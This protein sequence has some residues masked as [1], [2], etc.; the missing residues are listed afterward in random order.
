MASI[1]IIM[2]KRPTRVV[3]PVAVSYQSVLGISPA[4]AEPL[5][6]AEDVN[7]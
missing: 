7:A 5:F 4:K 6:P 3:I 2:K 1:G